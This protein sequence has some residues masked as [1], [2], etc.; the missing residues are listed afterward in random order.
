MNE[1]LL[2]GYTQV[3]NNVL[4]TLMTSNLSGAELRVMLTVLRY[5]AGFCRESHKLSSG[6][7]SKATGLN[8]RTVKRTV[9]RLKERGL[10]TIIGNGK[11]INTIGGG[12]MT[13][14]NESDQWSNDPKTSGEMTTSDSG[15]MTTQE[16]Y[17][18]RYK[19]REGKLPIL[20]GERTIDCSG[21]AI[22]DNKEHR[23]LPAGVYPPPTLD[24]VISYCRQMSFT[25]SPER[26][27]NYYEAIG[28]QRNGQRIM[29]W[30]AVARNWQAR[31]RVQPVQEEVEKD[32][33]GRPIP[34]EFV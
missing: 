14:T 15:Q 3:N 10:V 13:T 29:N 4:H 24:D 2:K 19:E 9:K 30:K 25:F 32:D 8:E 28:W 26:F 31:E 6:F 18:E 17:R 12:Q 27:F 22:G 34:P 11:D 33:W 1:N 16:R 5:T 21:M 7:I 20:S 23:I